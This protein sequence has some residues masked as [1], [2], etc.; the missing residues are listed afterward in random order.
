V[1]QQLK[2]NQGS[3]QEFEVENFLEGIR[4]A[5]GFTVDEESVETVD[6]LDLPGY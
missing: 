6:C 2:E 3:L 1:W 5:A 4:G